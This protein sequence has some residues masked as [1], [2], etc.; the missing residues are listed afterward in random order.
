ML[1]FGVDFDL[2]IKLAML[3]LAMWGI[4]ELV[5]KVNDTAAK[6]VGIG[7]TII[8]LMVVITQMISFIETVQTM[9]TF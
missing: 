3:G 4:E 7:S 8:F 9:F 1:G 6:Y 2:I 5:K